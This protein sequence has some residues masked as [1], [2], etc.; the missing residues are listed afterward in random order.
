MNKFIKILIIGVFLT[1]FIASVICLACSFRIA[2]GCCQN[3][4]QAASTK[5]ESCLSHCAKQKTFAV[6]VENQVLEKVKDQSQSL[7]IGLA[8]SN[9]QT[10]TSFLQ[11][12]L[13]CINKSVIKLNTGQ[14]WFTPLLNHAPP[15][16]F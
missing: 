11:S 9:L 12:D 15:I 8:A 4:A 16:F 13:H 10:T 7:K 3:K 6:N 2:M 5:D 1:G 14:I